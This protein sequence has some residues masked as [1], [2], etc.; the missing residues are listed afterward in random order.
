MNTVVINGNTYSGNNI[1]VKNGKVLIDGNDV[2]PET[3]E[4]NI[5][6][7]GNIESLKVDSCNT[8]N[9]TGSVTNVSTVSAKVKVTGDV[10]GGIQTVSGNVDCGDVGGSIN[11]V[12]GNIRN[13]T[14]K[15]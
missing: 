13:N 15:D 2:T 6:V 1:V 14:K 3:K 11:S 10:A 7:E 8:V 9:V 12:S 5:S 4:I